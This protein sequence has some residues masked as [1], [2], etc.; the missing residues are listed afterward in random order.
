MFIYKYYSRRKDRT[1][2]PIGDR[3]CSC[4]FKDGIKENG[5][6]KFSWSSEF[7]F[8]DSIKYRGKF[9]AV[10]VHLKWNL[11]LLFVVNTIITFLSRTVKREKESDSH[12]QIKIKSGECSILFDECKLQLPPHITDHPYELT[13]QQILRS[14]RFIFIFFISY[15]EE[16]EY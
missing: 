8:Q 5:P 12:E 1:V 13:F 11:F 2:I 16:Q 15:C 10:H 6:T 7:D 14:A 9:Y 4:H 3:I